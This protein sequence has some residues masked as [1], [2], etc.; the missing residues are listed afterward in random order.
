VPHVSADGARLYY[1]IHG[2]GDPLLLIPGFGS[3]T[4]VYF[5]NIAPLAERF[6]VIVFDPRGSGR[7]EVP[8]SGY[9]MQQFVDDCIAVMHEAGEESAHVVG[10]SFGGMIAQ[11]FAL[12]HPERTR[13]LVLICTTPGGAHHV[14]P[15]PEQ[16]A[17]F[18]AAG[19]IVDPV[20]AVRS[21]YTL[22]YSDAYVAAHDAEIAER[23]LANAH[24]RS[25]PEGRMG[26]LTAVSQHD[27][28]ERLRDLSMPVLVLHGDCDGVVP[29]ENS[30]K[31][32]AAIPSARLKVYLGA[33]HICFT[34]CAD[35]MN[36]DIIDFLSQNER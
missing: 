10:A 22:H 27:T 19:D 31:I 23:A 30:R 6:K 18:M 14:A 13:R 3:T 11:N 9:S 1:E 36:R 12:A 32:A 4:L 2:E 16:M 15:P 35:E 33:K 7:S 34:E 24:L 29:V 5:A 20:A 21:T 8:A 26:Q 28:L 25:K 17:V